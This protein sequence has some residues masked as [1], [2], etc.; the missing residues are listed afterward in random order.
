MSDESAVHDLESIGAEKGD[1]LLLR[2]IENVD[3]SWPTHADFGKNR[4]IQGRTIDES[5]LDVHPDDAAL[6]AV[7]HLGQ[8]RPDDRDLRLLN[9]E[10]VAVRQAE[11]QEWIGV[12]VE[13]VE[14][15][16]G[17]RAEPREGLDEDVAVE[18]LG[19][20]QRDLDASGASSRYDSRRS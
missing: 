19:I 1:E 4:P 13:E 18:A 10:H 6:D 5:Q 14:R 15:L 17:S 12:V 8:L 7:V 16:F 2:V 9:Q 20:R 11:R 3:Q